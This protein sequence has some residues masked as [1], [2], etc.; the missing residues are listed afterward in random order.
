MTIQTE[1]ILLKEGTE[2]PSGVT[3]ESVRY[4]EGWDRVANLT[5]A[6][7]DRRL[8]AAGWTLFYMAAECGAAAFAREE[9]AAV[10]K[11]IRR[12]LRSEEAAKFNC[13]EIVS[14]KLSRWLGIIRARVSAHWRHI[15]EG[16]ILF[17]PAAERAT[18]LTFGSP[19]A[20]ASPRPEHT[21]LPGAMLQNR[22]AA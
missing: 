6:E 21:P 18:R 14:V 7:L 5:P 11:A 16:P 13:L 3:I 22:A 15:Q 10:R 20:V 9:E 1:T 8:Q 2:T 19:I 4:A 17:R 12:L